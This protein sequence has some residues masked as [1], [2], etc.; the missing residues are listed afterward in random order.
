MYLLFNYFNVNFSTEMEAVYNRAMNVIQ[1]GGIEFHNVKFSSF[2]SMKSR[3]CSQLMQT[4]KFVS[5]NNLLLQVC[6]LKCIC[7]LFCRLKN[8]MF[9]NI[10]FHKFLFL[11]ITEVEDEQL[12]L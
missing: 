3:N 5:Y 1:C 7:Y 8:V 9:S 10:D 4:V 2:S 12:V 6:I 11:L